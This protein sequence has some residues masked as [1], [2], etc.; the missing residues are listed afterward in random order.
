MLL[1]L[2][3]THH[4]NLR[5]HQKAYIVY[6]GDTQRLRWN[7]ATID[8]HTAYL[9]L[10]QV[11]KKNLIK[12]NLK[13]GLG[14]IPKYREGCA[15]AQDCSELPGNSFA[16]LH[17][18]KWICELDVIVKE[19]K[20]VHRLMHYQRKIIFRKRWKIVYFIENAGKFAIFYNFANGN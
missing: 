17:D 20:L 7:S 11:H 16:G 9:K 2:M 4:L 8:P 12:I 3:Q 1:L 6:P 5:G 18:A 19:T 10:I 14:I 13:V 15:N